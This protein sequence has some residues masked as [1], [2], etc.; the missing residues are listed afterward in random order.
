[1]KKINLLIFILLWGW[2]VNVQAS[3]VFVNPDMS[4]QY[5]DSLLEKNARNDSL[6]PAFDGPKAL[7]ELFRQVPDLLSIGDVP[8]GHKV[9]T[10][11]K[12]N[13]IFVDGTREDDFCNI[14][15]SPLSEGL[16]ASEWKIDFGVDFVS[17]GSNTVIDH[18]KLCLE[19]A[20]EELG[21]AL[22]NDKGEVVF[23]PSGSQEK[24]IELYRVNAD[25]DKGLQLKVLQ[26]TQRVEETAECPTD[27]DSYLML[28]DVY[29]Q[30]KDKPADIMQIQQELGGELEGKVEITS[31]AYSREWNQRYSEKFEI[32]CDVNDETCD[33][34]QS[35]DGSKSW[36]LSED[37][38]HVFE[39]LPSSFMGITS[40]PKGIKEGG[41]VL[42]MK[43]IPLSKR[44]YLES[45]LDLNGDPVSLGLLILLN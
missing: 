19:Q 16:V 11:L 2:A 10:R 17:G 38:D 14:F 13:I 26:T 31:C 3:G 28:L 18:V 8:E 7:R 6:L 32:D 23:I 40:G 30:S 27:I 35:Q 12:A 15:S 33:V 44:I 42:D 9:L 1:M 43:L 4:W 5:S 39:F 34:W 37:K 45:Y 21:L 22:Q 29:K 36:K 41:P 24:D 20:K 25:L